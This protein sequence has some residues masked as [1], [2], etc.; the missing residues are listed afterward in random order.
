MISD[1]GYCRVAVFT[2]GFEATNVDVSLSGNVGVRV[3]EFYGDFLL[4]II[5]RMQGVA[6]VVPGDRPPCYGV[7]RA[8]DQI[9][10]GIKEPIGSFLRGF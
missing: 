8:V 7:G 5:R 10:T 9:S 4:R 1:F 6:A 3:Q 2:V